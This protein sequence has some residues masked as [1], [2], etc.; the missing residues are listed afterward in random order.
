M[1][2]GDLVTISGPDG[3][4]GLPLAVTPMV[5]GV[6]WA[7]GRVGGRSTTAALGVP[8]GGRVGVSDDGGVSA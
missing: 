5:D 8:V 4:V 3:S 2:P 7:P 6:L 1:I